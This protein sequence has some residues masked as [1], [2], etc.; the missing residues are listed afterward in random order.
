[1]IKNRAQPGFVLLFAVLLVSVVLSISLVLFNIT[2]RQ[3]VLSTTSRDSQLAYYASYA[4]LDCALY[5]EKNFDLLDDLPN[6]PKDNEEQCFGAYITGTGFVQ[7]DSSASCP[8]E[9]GVSVDLDTTYSNVSTPFSSTLTVTFANQTC[10]KVEIFKQTPDIPT[11]ILDTKIVSRGYN[12]PEGCT[13]PNNRTI[14]RA[15]SV[16]YNDNW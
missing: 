6:T 10:A 4:G 3:L 13:I 5:W 15:N 1:M 11:D 8:V 9:C 14:E 2:L 16:T 7:P 12:R